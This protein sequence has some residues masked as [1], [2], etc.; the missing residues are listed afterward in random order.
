MMCSPRNLFANRSRCIASS[1]RVLLKMKCFSPQG[2]PSSLHTC[3]AMGSASSTPKTASFLSSNLNFCRTSKKAVFSESS[4][5]AYKYAR[6]SRET[7]CTFY[8]APTQ[9]SY[10][11]NTIH[12]WQLTLYRP[13]STQSGLDPIITRSRYYQRNRWPSSTQSGHYLIIYYMQQLLST[14]PVTIIHTVRSLS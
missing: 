13:S 1:R 5:R 2:M 7:L 14:Q 10:Q 12:Q 9:N 3:S 6:R 8:A 4:M 11:T